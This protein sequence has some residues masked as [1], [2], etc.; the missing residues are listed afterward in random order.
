MHDGRNVE[1]L[2]GI[3]HQNDDLA[4]CARQGNRDD[5]EERPLH[6]GSESQADPMAEQEQQRVSGDWRSCRVRPY[7]SEGDCERVIKCQYDTKY[8]EM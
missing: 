2:R 5:A 8:V 1:C 7:C 3:P 6:Q 4:D